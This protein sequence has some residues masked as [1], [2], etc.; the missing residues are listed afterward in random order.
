ME[1]YRGGGTGKWQNWC[2]V[3][4]EWPLLQDYTHFNKKNEAQLAKIV[5]KS[6][7]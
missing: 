6:R 1:H 7:G 3:M 5:T 4:D 2:Y